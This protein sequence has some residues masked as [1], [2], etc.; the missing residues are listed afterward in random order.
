[1]VPVAAPT[2]SPASAAAPAPPTGGAIGSHPPGPVG[3]GSGP[4][5]SGGS[6]AI[7]VRDGEEYALAVT[8]LVQPTAY[9]APGD[10]NLIV[11]FSSEESESPSFGLQLWDDGSGTQRGLWSSGDAM[12]GER[13]LAPLAEGVP[14]E[15]VLCFKASSGADGFYLLLLDG[16]PVDARAWVSL[17]D[18]GSSAAQIDVGLFR[19]GEPVAGAS[20]VLVGPT[21]L[22]D[23]LESVLP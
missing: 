12:G 16:Q 22:G 4:I 19:D 5:G 3:A 9:R 21:R 13:F 8:F 11:Q 14:H 15:A 20:D 18:S 1:V 7:E 17:I 10:E 2:P 6:E 23:T